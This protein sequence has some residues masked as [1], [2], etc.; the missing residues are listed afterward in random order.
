MKR[1]VYINVEQLDLPTALV[2]VEDIYS[3]GT[4]QL[5]CPEDV[6]FADLATMHKVKKH[7]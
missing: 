6:T 3:T 4:S 7:L 5:V 2:L 1:G